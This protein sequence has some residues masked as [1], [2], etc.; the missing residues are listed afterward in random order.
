MP[1]VLYFQALFFGGEDSL[2]VFLARQHIPGLNIVVDP[3]ASVLV[4]IVTGLL[5]L[6]IKEVGLSF[7]I[8]FSE[9]YF[10]LGPKA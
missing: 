2:P 3:C 9:L 1:S 6:G 10:W 4:F 8:S 5:C 7:L